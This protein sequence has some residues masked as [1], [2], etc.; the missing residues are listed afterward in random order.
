[1]GE[2]SMSGDGAPLTRPERFTALNH[3]RT[4]AKV[5]KENGGFCTICKNRKP[6]FGLS[7]CKASPGRMFPQCE[8]DGQTPTFE[9]DEA[10]L[11]GK[12]HG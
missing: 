9:L 10:T 1:M 2:G 12:V 11:K 5:I 3:S 4:A 6:Y 8:E 7:R